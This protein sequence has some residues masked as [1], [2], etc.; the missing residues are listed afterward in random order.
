[1]ACVWCVA[2]RYVVCCKH[3]AKRVRRFILILA[4]CNVVLRKIKHVSLG[5]IP[6]IHSLEQNML[7]SSMR[8][9]ERHGKHEER[10]GQSC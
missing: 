10:K 4:S 8:T 2:W 5:C 7:D 3:H 6:V 1:M 9:S